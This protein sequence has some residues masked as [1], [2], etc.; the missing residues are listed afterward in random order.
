MCKKNCSEIVKAVSGYFQNKPKFIKRISPGDVFL[1]VLLCRKE[2]YAEEKDSLY[3]SSLGID[4]SQIFEVDV[5][6]RPAV[7]EEEVE[8]LKSEWPCA[9]PAIEP[10]YSEVPLEVEQIVTKYH[11]STS[12]ECAK[13]SIILDK[14]G[15][16]T[17]FTGTK[18]SEDVFNHS[19]IRMVQNTSKSTEGYLCTDRTVIVTGEPCLVCGMALIH[20]RVRVIYIAGSQSE[21]GPYTKYGIHE[22]K[23]L[24]HRIEVY[25]IQEQ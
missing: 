15:L 22:S 11:T 9:V 17:I 2:E 7:T 5:P 14:E 8:A 1:K 25:M 16:H 18:Q 6:N 12:Q 19:A 24:N 20:G 13:A 23:A 3:L 21:D 10:K 4:T